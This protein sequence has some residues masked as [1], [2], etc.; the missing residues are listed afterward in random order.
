[1]VMPMMNRKFISALILLLSCVTAHTQHNFDSIRICH[2]NG[3]LRNILIG[4]Y[5][6]EMAAGQLQS[7]ASTD[8]AISYDASRRLF[9]ISNLLKNSSIAVQLSDTGAVLDT[10]DTSFVLRPPAPGG[11]DSAES[12]SPAVSLFSVGDCS[13]LAESQEGRLTRVSF[14]TTN[15]YVVISLVWIAGKYSWDFTIESA[16]HRNPVLLTYVSNRPY[17]LSIQ[18][19][20]NRVGIRLLAK[21]KDGIFVELMGQKLYGNNLFASDKSLHLRYSITG[22]LKGNRSK[23]NLVCEE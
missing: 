22:R 23:F 12:P 8:R 19:D 10:G 3:E 13:F 20:T 9:R 11:T 16:G 2:N 15:K 18:D 14:P 17:L 4:E 1:M 7:L 21:K 5:R 6:V